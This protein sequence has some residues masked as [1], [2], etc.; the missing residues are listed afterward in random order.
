MHM[1]ETRGYHDLDF[2][3][4]YCKYNLFD[5]MQDYCADMGR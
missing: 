4:D 3:L 2:D 5:T 1:V